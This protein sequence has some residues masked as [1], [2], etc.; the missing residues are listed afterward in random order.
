MATPTDVV[1]RL[2]VVKSGPRTGGHT[3]RDPIHIAA[4]AFHGVPSLATILKF[5]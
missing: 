4:N 2:H 3:P 1:D 5:L